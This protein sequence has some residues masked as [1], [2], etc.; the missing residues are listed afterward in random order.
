LEKD[1]QIEYVNQKELKDLTKLPNIK[2]IE[3]SKDDALL[4]LK[5][6]ALR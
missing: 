1:R 3:I 4:F 6:L 5:T 2:A